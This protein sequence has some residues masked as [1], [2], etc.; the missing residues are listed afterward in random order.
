MENKED[1]DQK[2]VLELYFY[3]ELAS[4]EN[5]Y[6]LTVSRA[7]SVIDRSDIVPPLDDVIRTRWPGLVL[8]GM[9]KNHSCDIRACSKCNHDL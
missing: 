6:H 1:L 5:L 4:Q 2:M 3:D 7:K 8:I 9:A